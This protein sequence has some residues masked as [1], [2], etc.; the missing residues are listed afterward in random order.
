[1]AEKSLNEFPRELRILFTKGTEALQRDNFD[2]AIALF[3]QILQKDPALYDCRK[4]LRVAQTKKAGDGGG[5]LKKLWSAA[6]SQPMVGKGQLALRTNPAEALHIAEQ[7]LNNDPN[8]SGAHTLVVEAAAALELPRTAVL[9]LENLAKNSPKDVDVAIKYATALA[10]SGEVAR[11]EQ[12]LADL[13]PQFPADQDLALALK[14]LSARKTMKAGGYD[15]L[16]GGKGSYRD[17]LKNKE[18]AV[19]LEQENRQVKSEDTAES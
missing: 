2:Y 17:I 15:A 4:A 3:N 16:E 13:S 19:T 12:I 1:M 7:I 18:E 8:N 6:S 11:G 10:D 14:N 9:S 5:M